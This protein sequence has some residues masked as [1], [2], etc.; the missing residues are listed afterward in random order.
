MNAV[1]KFSHKFLLGAL[2]TAV[3][4]ALEINSAA[5]S[6][7]LLNGDFENGTS[8]W[9]ITSPAQWFIWATGNQGNNNSAKY[10]Y[11]GAAAPP[12]GSTPVNNGNCTVYQTVTIP[13]NA[14]ALNLN[15]WLKVTTL[16]GTTTPYDYLFV[17][18]R[19][20]NGTVLHTDG[21]YS[22]TDAVTSSWV[23]K[24]TTL[25]S[26]YAGQTIQLAF[27]GTTDS[28]NKTVFRIDDVSLVATTT[29]PDLT[30]GTDWL[31]NL[32]PHPGDTVTA[33]LAIQNSTST[34]A[35]PFHIGFYWS[36]SSSFSGTPPFFEAPLS[37]CP[38]NGTTPL[39]QNITIN[40][41]TAPGTYYLGYKIDNQN[42]VSESNENN[43]GIFYWTV[44]VQATLADLVPQ[45]ITVTPNP[46]F[47]GSSVDVN[48]TVANTGG[49]A[50]PASHTKVQ[51]KDSSNV[52]LI[53]QTFS[54]SAIGANS[55]VN[56]SRNISLTGASAGTYYAYVIVDN[57]SEVVQSNVANDLSAGSQ[58]TVQNPVVP[59]VT[60]L[61]ASSVG[62]NSAVLNG[63][64]NNDGG[65]AIDERRFDWGATS[66]GAW[67][68]T[69]WTN[70]VTVSGNDFSFTLGNLLPARTYYFRAW[71]HNNQGWASDGIVAFTTASAPPGTATIVN[72]WW[73]NSV[74]VDGDG[75][76][77]SMRL[78]WDPDVAGGS[79]SL[80]V[81]EKI[82]YRPASGGSW[83]LETTTT[84]HTITGTTSS[85]RQFRDI[86]VATG[87]HD[88]YDWKI[89]IYRVGQ[90]TPDQTLD[91]ANATDLNDFAME[92]AANDVATDKPTARIADPGLVYLNIAH[93]FSASPSS[94]VSGRP[95]TSYRWRF[96]DNASV[97][98]DTGGVN[99]AAHTFET[100]DEGWV[101]VTVSDGTSSDTASIRFPLQGIGSP[102]LTDSASSLDPVNSAI[103]NFVMNPTLL[104]VQ[105]RGLPFV[106]QAFYNSKAFE[107]GDTNPG[108]LGF[109][110]THNFEVNVS[111]PW[112]E[113]GVRYVMISFGD[114]HR[115]K[116]Q[117]DG[118]SWQA[119]PGIYNKLTEI[120]DGVFVLTSPNQ[121][122]SQFDDAGK[123]AGIS[124]RNGNT[125]KVVWET[126]PS[127]A[128]KFRIARVELPGG[129]DPANPRKV[130]FA[131]DVV[132]GHLKTLTDPIGRTVEFT[133]DAAHDLRGIKNPRDFWTTYT[134]DALHQMLTGT[135]A[136]SKMF[137]RNVYQDRV[138]VEQYDADNNKTTFE[139][140]FMAGGPV[141]F[142][143]ITRIAAPDNEVTEDHH[144]E[145][146]QLTER[147]VWI[148]D[149]VNAA[150][151]IALSVKFEYDPAT[152]DR[153][154]Y[155]DR[156][157]NR[158]ED[159]Y[160]NGNITRSVN[161]DGG[162]TSTVYDDFNNPTLRI[163]ALG[164]QE[165]W[166]YNASGNLIAY[167]FP[168]NPAAPNDYRRTFTVDQFGQTT[169]ATDANGNTTRSHFD[170]WGFGW[171]AEDAETP[172]NSKTF[173]PDGI[174]RR[175]G[176]TDERNNHTSYSLNSTGGVETTTLPDPSG[177]TTINQVFDEND[178]RTSIEDQLHRFTYFEF[179]NQDRQYKVRNHLNQETVTQFDTLGRAISV[180]DPKHNFSHKVYDLAGRLIEAR[181]QE[182]RRHFFIV[183]PNGN[184]LTDIDED[185]VKIEYVYDSMNRP[186][187]KR[188]YK[189]ATE[190]DEDITHY[191]PLGQIDWNEDA[192]Q[193]RTYF[194]YND[195]GQM[196][197]LVERSVNGV[198][199]EFTWTYDF[200]GHL[201]SAS[202]PSPTGPKTRYQT[203]TPRY[204]IATRID[205][206]G[207]TEQFFYD[208]AG[209]LDHMINADG[210]LISFVYDTLNRLITITP[211]T[212]P[213][214]QFTYDV[215]GQR[216]FMDDA[217]GRTAWTHTLLGQVESATDPFGKQLRFGY[218]E[219]GNRDTIVYPGNKTARFGYDKSNLLVSATDWQN[220][221]ITRSHT[222]GGRVSAISFP[223]GVTTSIG[224]DAAGRL[225]DIRHQK[226]P[227]VPFIHF[228]YQYDELGDV[229]NVSP[230]IHPL[231]RQF[232][233]GTSSYT[234]DPANQLLTIDGLPVTHDNRGNLL[235][236]K[237]SPASPGNDSLTWDYDGRLIAFS[238]TG[239]TGTNSYNGLGHRLQTTSGLET[240]R[241]VVDA[242]GPLAQVMAETDGSGNITAY[243]LYAGGL[244]ARILPDDSVSY[245][246]S[247]RQGNT[248]ALTDGA[249]SITDLYR[250]DE[251]GCP[252][253]S[254]GSTPNPFRYLG[255]FGVYDNGD[256]TLFARKRYYH[257]DL[258]RFLSRDPLFGSPQNGQSLNRYVYALNNPI[259]LLDVSGFS[260]Q[261]GSLFDFY[262][263]DARTAQSTPAML[264]PGSGGDLHH[265]ILDVAGLVPLFGEP[266]DVLN[267]VIYNLE[268]DHVNAA[269]SYGGAIPIA[270]WAATGGK[271]IGRGAKSLDELVETAQRLYPKKAGRIEEHHITPKYL[272]GDSNGPTVPLD[273]SY[274][275]MITNEFRSL[276]G[277]GGPKPSQQQLQEVLRK[278]YETLP[279]PPGYTF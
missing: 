73:T 211:P 273:A 132:S 145:K 140:P 65:S 76:K 14:T 87:V 78:N 208:D 226:A 122:K 123:L 97:T 38:G 1:A 197:R 156:N 91:G 2:V 213:P 88:L 256:G 247:D 49:T 67:P 212:G 193:R 152:G 220:R 263:G 113:N 177:P 218:D 202:H 255:G 199:Q 149:P 100:G 105:A 272:G 262:L 232:A 84:S 79:G 242:T 178:N 116:Y 214:I 191:N 75:Y 170:D 167:T 216:T 126:V 175:I 192:K 137:V 277:Y 160:T 154:A 83:N 59:T 66:D 46:A 17:E 10:C 135:N 254:S 30:K 128:T 72:A 239:V 56:E 267:G 188:R 85:D 104:T 279:L 148:R 62:M 172:P 195:A 136:R 107:V 80:S 53:Q 93:D 21:I 124:D 112:I 16:D 33:S 36:T 185:G 138:V 54:T 70:A 236:G 238:I 50:A 223:N 150:A 99:H 131:Y 63:R 166:D 82:Y 200:E 164:I 241:F 257:P 248:L 207:K 11:F 55:S 68:P 86:A 41:S 144:N 143:R 22:N 190:Y 237:L 71:A 43:N 228:G 6:N 171:K 121:I 215:A 139:Y 230:A 90:A 203:Y 125:L 183:D 179:D 182:G 246:H 32:S 249:G 253:G 157:G 13:S 96:S 117:F 250:F 119:E 3:L 19:N 181:D 48:Y 264:P 240:K 61:A 231:P 151:F 81:F 134:Y 158:F 210:Q 221:T 278:V 163:N 271:W 266:A 141:G 18:I 9:S 209:N 224:H 102:A 23:Q 110:W 101:E 94:P 34:A 205:E 118:T 270:G 260:Q 252:E 189:S 147:K 161:P 174:N 92:S 5:Q 69:N 103:G 186:I 47:I 245:Y 153:A 77:R 106:F 111:P 42:E 142:T 276:W 27:H 269:L 233:A 219:N 25:S 222:L 268:G 8:S 109:G 130:L 258:G 162:I 7:L 4:A 243:Y 261:D 217:L 39:D 24:T 133:V 194:Y 180:E 57:N 12:D 37:G 44:T 129:P 227:A 165:K 235:S 206:N 51:I 198:S 244:A 95:I 108:P 28:S 60:T 29:K 201:L 40:S 159:E 58:F 155:I 120:A 259:S 274:H 64:I 45:S 146:L 229:E 169:A 115:E 35:G 52:L 74:D 20:T 26:A 184:I 265:V 176:M 173:D 114:G 234:V 204:Q 15:F 98:V 196:V 225:N 168:F 187:K 31:N 275:Q 89:E 127:D 251:F